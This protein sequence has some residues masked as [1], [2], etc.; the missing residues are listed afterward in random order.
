MLHYCLNSSLYLNIYSL[1]NIVI[2]VH[3]Y[4]LYVYLYIFSRT[5][6]GKHSEPQTNQVYDTPA[7]PSYYEDVSNT[8]TP[9]MEL[10]QCPAYAST[11]HKV[12]TSRG[13]RETRPSRK[14]NKYC[15]NFI[16]VK[17]MSIPSLSSL[18]R[19]ATVVLQAYICN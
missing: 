11:D 19:A 17:Y 5:Q 7:L 3:V 2:F 8:P 12:S 6:L 10:S 15:Q 16:I 18:L 9:A 1:Y 14:I 13:R 4:N